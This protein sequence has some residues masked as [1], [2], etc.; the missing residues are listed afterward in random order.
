[1]PPLS[2]GDLA[3]EAAGPVAPD[4]VAPMPVEASPRRVRARHL[5][6]RGRVAFFGAALAALCGASLVAATGRP[7]TMWPV[8]VLLTVGSGCGVA[9]ATLPADDTHPGN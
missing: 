2:A 8:M 4:A 6:L 1:M 3:T 5:L 7:M 9:A